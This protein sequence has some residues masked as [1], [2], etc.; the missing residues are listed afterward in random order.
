MYYKDYTDPFPSF[1]YQ[2]SLSQPRYFNIIHI[3]LFTFV[4]IKILFVTI[5]L[6]Y[7][8][9][10]PKREKSF[11]QMKY[12]EALEVVVKKGNKYFNSNYVLKVASY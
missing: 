3:L 7:I 11:T 1:S 4:K 2:Y 6:Y 8:S 9:N 12:I 5:L 10:S